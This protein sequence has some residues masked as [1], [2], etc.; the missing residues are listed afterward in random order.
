MRNRACIAFLRAG[1][2]APPGHSP[3]YAL[4]SQRGS[5]R[6]RPSAC[7]G[8]PG[9]RPRTQAR[10]KSRERRTCERA[11]GPTPLQSARE[12]PR[13][14]MQTQSR[15]CRALGR[16]RLY[17]AGQTVRPHQASDRWVGRGRHAHSVTRVSSLVSVPA[18]IDR[19]TRRRPW[20]SQTPRRDRLIGGAFSDDPIKRLVMA[21]GRQ[22]PHPLRFKA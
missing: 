22:A 7:A 8:A 10:P 21:L 6:C 11:R 5:P 4:G 12:S 13:R 16:G 2:A 15:A 9:T 20:R 18:A 3:P 19:S 14:T 17:P 1:D